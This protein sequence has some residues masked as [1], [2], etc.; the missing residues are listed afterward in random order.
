MSIFT[1][2]TKYKQQQK[3]YIDAFNK[4]FYF[5]YSQNNITIFYKNI[6]F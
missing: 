3:R 6:K 2:L 5:N 1:K 4:E